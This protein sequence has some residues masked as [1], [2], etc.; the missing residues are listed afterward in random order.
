MG[1][2]RFAIA[3][4]IGALAKDIFKDNRLQL[5]RIEKQ[6]LVLGFLGGAL[7]GAYIGFVTDR[8]FLTS[9]LAG[10]V[11]VDAIRDLLPTNDSQE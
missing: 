9:A 6:T 3:G 2:Y 1:L 5:P 8:T 7:V 11:G 4:A 10:W